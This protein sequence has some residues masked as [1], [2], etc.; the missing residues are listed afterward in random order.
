MARDSRDRR[1]LRE[2]FDAL[3][4]DAFV[5]AE[6]LARQTLAEQSAVADDSRDLATFADVVPESATF[7]YRMPKLETGSCELST[8]APT[9]MDVPDRRLG[10]YA[11]WTGT[12]MIIWGGSTYFAIDLQSG[13]RYN[14]LTDTWIPTSMADG[15]PVSVENATVVWTG[16]EMIVWGGLYDDPVAGATYMNSGARYSP[17]TDS[18][19]PVSTGSN[20]P[21]ERHR[22]TAVWTGTEMIVWGGYVYDPYYGNVYLN[23][24]GRYD[25]A[26]DTW[27]PVSNGPNTPSSRY[28]HT[29]VWTGRE[30]IVW[31]GDHVGTPLNTGGKYDPSNDTWTPTSTGTNVPFVREYHTA[32]WTGNRMIVWGGNGFSGNPTNTGGLYDPVSNTWQPTSTGAGVP[33]GSS[34]HTAIWSGSAMILWGG[35]VGGGTS[36]GAIYDPVGNTWR[37][38]AVNPLGAR[39]SHTAVWTGTEMVVWGGWD[40]SRDTNTGARYDPA[41]D[42]WITMSSNMT[43]PTGRQN[44]AAVWTGAEM[45]VWGGLDSALLPAPST[46]STGGRYLP[47]TDS[48]VPM[49]NTNA[50]ESR[51]GHIAVWT[52][53]EMIVWG[54]NPVYN[55]AAWLTSGGRYDPLTDNWKPTSNDAS[56][57]SANAGRSAVWTGREM[58]VWGGSNIKTGGRYDPGS[59]SW[60]PTSTGANVPSGGSSAVWSGTRMIVWNGESSPGGRYDPR[61][62]TWASMASGA[63]L[64]GVRSG[65]SAVWSGSE[66]LVWG[67]WSGGFVNTGARYNP[68]TDSWVP[69]SNGSGVASPRSGHQ[70]AWTGSGMIVWGG[71]WPS[72]IAANGG[73]IY[74]PAPDKWSELSAT[75][76]API[77]RTN[78]V[79]VWTGT[80]MIVW[81]GQTGTSAGG[82]YCAC[83]SGLLVY[84]D[85]D[86]DGYGD[87]AY[88]APSCDGSIAPGYVA[89][90]L[91]CDDSDPNVHPGAGEICNG[92]DDN[93]DGQIDEDANGVDSDADGVHNACDNCP[94]ISNTDQ[95]DQNHD[96][97][98]DACDVNDGL[99]YVYGSD[100]K[101]R[102]E[103]Q[104]EVGYD[105]WNVYTGDLAVLRSTGQYTQA[106]GS[107]PLASRQCGL[108]DLNAYDPVI[109]EPASVEYMLVSGVTA[110][111]EGSLGTNSAGA[112]RPNA[113][114][115]P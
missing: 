76:P 96:G 106:P 39:T 42:T 111:A 31:G 10:H 16:S 52:G 100:D 55:G 87:S 68:I 74:A 77:A 89:N 82:V 32:V 86:G 70:A 59:D 6:T 69:M 14:P 102:I 21:T 18:W 88:P 35:D 60:T 101:S 12:E 15:V 11:V 33:P 65:Y 103:W 36:A 54:G 47:A 104:P 34:S 44:A 45:I 58:I 105:S 79:S 1:M 19:Q 66:M 46:L 5:I 29:A 84:R 62:D 20:T 72:S 26:T 48:W 112:P 61:T 41:S 73:G 28:R 97:V 7:P 83:P 115:C 38:T 95:T 4:N 63:A 23:T 49:S 24:G 57:P 67:G 17:A 9:H 13:G 51:Y 8:W 50:P 113:N 92:I 114:P 53:T 99:I 108:A 109:P 30:M 81:G 80:A 94:S 3:G 98:G 2:L 64:L 91:D 22:H 107:G 71:T 25:P 37:A 56:T 43:V 78:A 40:Q 27:Q 93:C 90:Q 75:Y 110:G 85:N